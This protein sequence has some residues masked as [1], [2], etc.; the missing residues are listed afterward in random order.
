M[1]KFPHSCP[2]GAA[3]LAVI[4]LLLAQMGA[5]NHAY[6]HVPQATASVHATQPAAHTLCDDCVSFAPVL[7]VA[8]TSAMPA[9]VAPPARVIALRAAAVSLLKPRLDLAFRSRAPPVAA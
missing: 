5:M 9:L 2:F 7:A 1:K 4:V 6:S 8:G 3:I